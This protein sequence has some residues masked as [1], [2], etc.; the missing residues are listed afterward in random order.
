MYRGR[1]FTHTSVTIAKCHAG[2]FTEDLGIKDKPISTG[3]VLR[4]MFEFIWPKN[5]KQV[6]IRVLIALSLLLLSKLLNI[7]VPFMFKYLIDELN[8]G[9]TL[10]VDTTESAILS[11]VT[12]LLI[13]YGAARAGAALFGELRNA[14]FANV[15]HRSIRELAKRVFSHIHK[16]DLSFHL[17]RQTGALSKAIDRGTKG[18]SFILSALVFNIVPTIF[19]VGL[20]SG[21]LWYKF[22]LSYA[23]VAIGCITGYTAYTFAVTQWRTKF[24]VNMNKA[25]NEAGNKAI[26]SL[27]NFE[28]VKYFNN[29]E[30]EIE[31]YGK[32]LSQYEIASIKTQTSLAMLNFGQNAIF[33]LGLTG[34]ML[35]AASGITDG[36]M[37]VGDLVAVNGLIFQ[38]SM[39]LTFLG[40][41]YREVKQSVTD[42][43]TM[44]RLTMIKSAVKDKENAPPFQIS[45]TASSIVFDNVTFGYLKEQKILDK[46]TFEVPSGK[47]VA[48]VGG[49]GSGKSTIIR[50]L[51]RFYDP[52]DGEIRINNENI[53]HVSLSSLRK[54]IG[55]VPQDTVLFHDTILYN[56]NYGN[57]KATKEQVYEA[58]KLAEVHNA[59]MRMPKQYDT[60]VGERGLKLSGGEK[61]RIAIARA[62]L[63]DPI[64]LV[65]DE[66]T[67][68]LDTV[69]E[70]AILKSLRTLT[71]NRTSIVIA[72]R[73]STV[74]DCDHIVILEKGKV[75]EQG[76]HA[77]LMANDKGYYTSLWNTYLLTMSYP[78]QQHFGIN[79]LDDALF[80][81]GTGSGNP[82]GDVMSMAHNMMNSFQMN[83]G[84]HMNSDP[85]NP[86]V[87][88]FGVSSMNV[89]QLA[90]GPDGRP[91]VIQAHDEKRMGPNGIWQTKKALK[92][93]DRGIDK[94]QV[95]YFVGDQGE[96]V[97]RHYDPAT[98][99]YRQNVQHRGYTQPN[100]RQQWQQQAQQAVR[101]PP[102]SQQHQYLPQGSHQ[103]Q[104][105]PAPSPYQYQ[106]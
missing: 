45:H 85:N 102:Q 35:L 77:E 59:I 92:D 58:A 100:F 67:A 26:D 103:Q 96:I 66:A 90:R 61:Q 94:M 27:I 1:F 40:S 33:S 52:Q 101:G 41:V 12:A 57:L 89:T 29:E 99:Q 62:L 25:D 30:H 14:I 2:S 3:Y 64:V 84:M 55:I 65:Y 68:H 74:I 91:H 24:R 47:K 54:A 15:A 78:I 105:L 22:G 50:L 75:L 21:V 49:S 53:Q 5:G 10:K 42:M 73:L 9:H 93:S 20:V 34:I 7:S 88:V 106:Y 16:L 4:A 60:M 39:P 36:S 98:G 46:L 48:I 76:S 32:V 86:N 13:G 71:K 11:M 63:K 38:L 72:H 70:Q 80:G 28:T 81:G 69:T 8:K 23:A 37:T 43:E 17:G 82:I 6:K 79:N 104:S 56:I 18:I 97:E 44:F 95:G 51:Y 83:S 87:K 19:E 31:R